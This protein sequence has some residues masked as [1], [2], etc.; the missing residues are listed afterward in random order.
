MKRIRAICIL[1]GLLFLGGC[2]ASGSG[3]EAERITVTD[4]RGEVQVPANPQRV[5]VLDFGHLDTLKE[6]EL[7]GQVVGTVTENAPAYLSD[8][9]GQYENVGTLKEPNMEKLAELQPDLIIIS[10]RL[11][12]FAGELEGIAPVLTLSTEYRDYW[13]SVQE[14]VRTL[15]RVFGREAEAEEKLRTLDGQLAALREENT[16]S[17]EQALV[18]LLNNGALSAFSTG[19]RFGI[20]FDAMGF[21]PVDTA[22]EES[23]HGQNI[24]YEGIMGIN[25]DILFILDRTKAIQEPNADASDLLDNGFVQGTEAYQK[26][27]IIHLTSDLWYLSGGGLESTRLMVEE[28]SVKTSTIE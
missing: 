20:L 25:P 4:S 22:I 26:G 19:S 2:Q 9:V 13:G 17:T 1:V 11:Q 24:G 16:T 23:T 28:I 8:F 21:L 7:E 5:A 27:Q 10:N 15:A 18:L 14:N 12:D 3:A 6:L